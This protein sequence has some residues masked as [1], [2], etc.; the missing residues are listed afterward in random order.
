[1]A[2]QDHGPRRGRRALPPMIGFALLAALAVAPPAAAQDGGLPAGVG[3]AI[4]EAVRASESAA[5]N[6]AFSAAI[7]DNAMRT[8]I[9]SRTETRVAQSSIAEA[10]VAGIARYPQA[11][12]AIV[13]AAVRRAPAHRDAVVR[14]AIFAFPIFAPQ[15]AAAAGMAPPALVAM[16]DPYLAPAPSYAAAPAVTVAQAAAPTPSPARA[17][18][19][20]LRWPRIGISELRFGIVHHD[21]GVFGNSKEGD[22]DIALGVRFLPLTG[23]IWEY[24]GNPR[25]FLGLNI[26]PS[27]DTSALDFGVN[28]D[29]EVWRQRIFPGPWAARPMTARSPPPTSTAKSWVRGCC[30][31]WPPRPAI[32]STPCIRCRSASTTCRTPA[33]STT[34]KSWTPSGLSTAITSRGPRRGRGGDGLES[35]CGRHGAAYNTNRR[36]S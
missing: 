4:E 2:A 25:Q 21:T 9:A 13:A 16:P 28:W 36:N 11:V 19:A 17:D 7:A 12:S 31:I 34:T 30:S 8:E 6:A 24:L 35:H 32:A 33:W 15:I 3:A 26:N 14:R 29:W 10:V 23:D 27:G 18:T 5:A 22:V 1:M 20:A